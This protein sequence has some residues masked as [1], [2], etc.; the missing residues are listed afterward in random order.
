MPTTRSARA[1]TPTPKAIEKSPSLLRARGKGKSKGKKVERTRASSRKRKTEEVEEVEED[2]EDKE[3]EVATKLKS[4]SKSK[5]AKSKAAKPSKSKTPPK[6]R[7]SPS[8]PPP[9]IYVPAPNAFN[10]RGTFLTETLSCAM[11]FMTIPIP[12]LLF[13]SSSLIQGVLQVMF[14]FLNDFFLGGI[15]SP[16][17]AL[18]LNVLPSPY[19]APTFM[20]KPRLTA[21][22]SA[23]LLTILFIYQ[24]KRM[25]YP[26]AYI[27]G[28]SCSGSALDCGISE[29]SLS[30]LLT[31]IC[32]LD[33]P[34]F[35]PP[36]L[37]GIVS[38]LRIALGVKTCL[39]LDGGVSGAALNPLIPAAFK[40][41]GGDLGLGGWLLGEVSWVGRSEATTL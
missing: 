26:E 31:V 28:P 36:G 2:E 18:I 12:V 33:V 20:T 24:V 16:P 30:L 35:V 6:K 38:S 3:V 40:V 39:V 4:R 21:T 13:P 15:L 14:I 10:W 1:K 22:L 9:F 11:L 8:T 5:A 19:G 25:V 23:H 34:S 29:G 17:V 41:G 37:R 32:S 7:R 27:F